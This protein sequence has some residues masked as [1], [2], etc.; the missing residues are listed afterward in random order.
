M[1]NDLFVKCLPPGDLSLGGDCCQSCSFPRP[2]AGEKEAEKEKDEGCSN[3]IV[4]TGSWLGP[5]H[6]LWPCSQACRR[7]G[8]CVD[9]ASG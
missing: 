9:R 2:A 8:P 7:A 6:G 4:L 1:F 5:A 3:L